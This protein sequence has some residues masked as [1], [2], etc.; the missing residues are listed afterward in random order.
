MFVCLSCVVKLQTS[1][2]PSTRFPL[3]GTCRA[4]FK[5]W[6]PTLKIFQNIINIEKYFINMSST[7]KD[8]H[9]YVFVM[10]CQMLVQFNV[11]KLQTLPECALVW[12]TI[13]VTLSIKGYGWFSMI[14]WHLQNMISFRCPFPKIVLACCSP[15][16]GHIKVWIVQTTARQHYEAI[17][18]CRHWPRTTNTWQIIVRKQKRLT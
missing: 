7:I 8:L 6:T 9:V 10:R 5:I 3:E 17:P 14:R 15:F 4:E 11:P 13:W 1:G 2:K 18:E 16:Q 12:R